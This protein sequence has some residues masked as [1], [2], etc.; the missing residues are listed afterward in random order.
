MEFRKCDYN[1]NETIRDIAVYSGKIPYRFHGVQYNFESLHNNE[2]SMYI[3]GRDLRHDKIIQKCEANAKLG[4]R[5]FV[6]F[7]WGPLIGRLCESYTEDQVIELIG[8]RGLKKL[9]Y[10]FNNAMEW[11]KKHMTTAAEI[12]LKIDEIRD[13]GYEVMDGGMYWS[14]DPVQIARKVDSLEEEASK[15]RAY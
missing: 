4:Q 13:K 12:R 10:H 11:N 6:S 3:T 14:Y 15:L 8:K 9:E 2:V 7:E 5:T 1:S